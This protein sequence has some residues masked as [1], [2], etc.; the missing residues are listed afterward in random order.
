MPMTMRSGRLK[1]EIAA[2]SRRNSGFE[3]TAKSASGRAC[4]DDALDL[5]AGA[6][7]HGGLGDDDREAVERA[8]DLGGGGVDV[9]QI[10]V[11]VAAPRGRAHRDEHGVGVAHGRGQVGGEGEPVRPD[12]G[13]DEVFEARLEDRDLAA[14][15]RRDALAVLVDAGDHMA[16]IGEARARHEAHIARPNHCNPHQSHSA[17]DIDRGLSLR[18]RGWKPG[19][20]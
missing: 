19:E 18:P 4:A 7:R 2:P 12:V 13:F 9:G 3:A 20:P 17:T 15:Q 6:H 1:S 8:R 11:P 5:V 14:R 10:R 16:E